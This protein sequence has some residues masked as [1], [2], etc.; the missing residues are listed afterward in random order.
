MGG[1]VALFVR[2]YGVQALGYL[3]LATGDQQYATRASRLLIIF[4]RATTDLA[5]EKVGG[6]PVIVHVAS[7]GGLPALCQVGRSL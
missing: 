3:Y 4:A 6:Y 1:A 7:G 2:R 5:V